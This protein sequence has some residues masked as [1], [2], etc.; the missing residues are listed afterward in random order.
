MQVAHGDRF[1]PG[2]RV[3]LQYPSWGRGHLRGRHA[4]VRAGRAPRVTAQ[5]VVWGYVLR[6]DGLGEPVSACQE[7]LRPIEVQPA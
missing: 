5:G 4:T 7:E 6:I 1:A 3:I 2:Q